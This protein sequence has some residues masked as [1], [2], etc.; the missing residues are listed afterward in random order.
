MRHTMVTYVAEAADP[1]EQPATVTKSQLIGDYRTF[2]G[3]DGLGP[4]AV[5]AVAAEPGA[6]LTNPAADASKRD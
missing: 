2:E 4:V 3:R 5:S 1:H 6:A